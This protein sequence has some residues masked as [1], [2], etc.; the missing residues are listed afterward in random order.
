MTDISADV[1]VVGA[2]VAGALFAE[3]L[4]AQGI[5]VAILEAGPRIDREE[6]FE[7][8]L[9]ATIKV[10]ESPYPLTPEAD[11]PVAHDVSHWYRQSG[12]D[13]F[14]STYL[15]QVGGTTWHWLGTCVRYVPNDFRMRSLYGQAVDWPITYDDLEPDYLEAEHELG[16]A[17]DSNEDLGSPRSGPFP[18]PP[19]PQSHLDGFFA[20]A[21]KGTVYAVHPTPQ[22]RN[23]VEHDGRPVCCGS[24]SCIPIC[25]VQAKYDATVHLDR[26]ESRGARV[27]EQCTAVQVALDG[28]DR[29]AGL[30]FRRPDGSEGVARGRVYA[31]AAHAIETPRL[32]LNSPGPGSAAVANGS[33]QVGR[34]LMDHPIQLSWAVAR[35]PVWPYRGPLSTSG[36]ETL[37]D[38]AYRR[39]RSS[40]RIEIGNDGWNWPTGGRLA[41]ADML[42]RQGLRG[43]EL[44]RTMESHA[45]RHVRMASLTEQLPEPGNRITLDPGERDHYGVPLPRIHYRVGRYARDGLAEARRIHDGIFSR[46]GT[47]AVWHAEDF[48]GA[49]HII[50]TCRMG[51]DPKTSVVNSRLRSHQHANLFIL[52]SSVF[53]TGATA[54]PTLTIAALSLRASREVRDVL[55]QFPAPR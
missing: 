45:S 16:V 9:G 28:D 19:I 24:G 32:L 48:Q 26:A 33:G 15:K 40:L 22:A 43:P 47:T 44:R 11:H 8:W 1:I 49:G 37:K 51:H 52:G 2:G 27:H 55:P 14:K 31:L 10:P 5:R 35:E 6:A 53:P 21:L 54:N 41:L 50:G 25:P 13:P 38:G 17:G 7:T 46:I 18:L 20:E 23:S 30:R 12:P 34:N 39:T 3:R 42:F 29:V 4:T 36:I